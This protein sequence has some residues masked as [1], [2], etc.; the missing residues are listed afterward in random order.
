LIEL[1]KRRDAENLAA[2]ETRLHEAT[3]RHAALPVPDRIV[4]D[5]EVSA[6]RTTAAGMKSDLERIERDIQRAHGA[7][8]QVGGAAARERLR[9]AT[10]AF[11]SRKGNRGGV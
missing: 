3:E 2:A 7:L 6:A 10:E 5:D 8:E 1:R 9:D 4:T 11:A